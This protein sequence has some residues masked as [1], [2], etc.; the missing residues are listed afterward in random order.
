M[1][2]DSLMAVELR[3]AVSDAV[4]TPLPATLL[5]DYPFVTAIA[6]FLMALNE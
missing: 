1:G 2:L 5:F 3:N 4:A 6:A